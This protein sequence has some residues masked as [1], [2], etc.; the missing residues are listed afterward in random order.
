MTGE[1]HDEQGGEDASEGAGTERVWLVERDYTDAGLVTV[2]Y[3]STDGERH[4]QQRL[5]KRMVVRSSV[6]AAREI[7]ADRLEP[8]PDAKRDRYAT[9]ASRMAD[10]HD[11]DNTV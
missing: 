7:Q 9:E 10:K 4:L 3:A 5:S 11:P 8:T 6:T 2:V 1:E